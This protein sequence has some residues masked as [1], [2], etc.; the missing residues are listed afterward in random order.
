MRQVKVYRNNVFAG[1][2]TE[3]NRNTYLFKYDENQK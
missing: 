3:E 1:L 2:L